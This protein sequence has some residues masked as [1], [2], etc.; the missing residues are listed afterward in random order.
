M[1]INHAL[2][3]ANTKAKAQQLSMTGKTLIL[4]HLVYD[5]NFL[6]GNEDSQ[7]L[8]DDS[9]YEQEGEEQDEPKSNKAS[10]SKHKGKKI[11][12]MILCWKT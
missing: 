6:R 8:G 10:S 1:M 3:N 5:M 9:E 12:L 4:N 11:E 2:R 7:S